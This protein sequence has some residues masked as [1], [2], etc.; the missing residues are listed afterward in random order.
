M[1]NNDLTPTKEI[2][3]PESEFT[4]EYN[5][6]KKSYVLPIITI[7]IL[8]FVVSFAVTF[9]VSS[10]KL[11]E[12]KKT[13][14]KNNGYIFTK[15]TTATSEYVLEGK[16]IYVNGKLVTGTYK[17]VDHSQTNVTSNDIL[18]GYSAYSNGELVKGKIPIYKGDV[19]FFPTTEDI[20]I[21]KGQYLKEFITVTGDVDL[22]SEN[23]KKGVTILGVQGSLE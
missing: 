13:E 5:V 21:K 1:K 8:C 3:I 10:P 9:F 15:Y 4:A 23:I 20:I 18:E 2:I 7:C 17:E 16:T 14:L 11:I 22:I 6:E 12:E 19:Y